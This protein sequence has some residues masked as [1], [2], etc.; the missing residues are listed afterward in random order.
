M[1][2]KSSR[3]FVTIYEMLRNFVI[4][5]QGLRRNSRNLL[6]KKCTPTGDLTELLLLQPA[7]L[8]VPDKHDQELRGRHHQV[9]MFPPA[10]V[11]RPAAAKLLQQAEDAGGEPTHTS[12]ITQA[13]QRQPQH[14]E[15]E[16]LDINLTQKLESFAPCYSQS[17]LLADLKKTILFSRLLHKKYLQQQKS[18]NKK[19]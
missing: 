18:R 11:C 8:H 2:E 19:T 14:P 6:T 10:A 13:G 5:S 12:L 7:G 9:S 3:I 15:M 16:F 17:L 4:L 1:P